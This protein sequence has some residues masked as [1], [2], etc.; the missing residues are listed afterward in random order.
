MS[1]NTSLLLAANAL[2][3]NSRSIEMIT[4]RLRH[5]LDEGGDIDPEL[6]ELLERIAKNLDGLS[7]V[8]A[9]E[10]LS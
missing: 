1:A 8:V 5:A 7:V 4:K 10:A 9:K 2:G 6:L 3:S